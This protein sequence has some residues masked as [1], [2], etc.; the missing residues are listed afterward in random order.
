LSFQSF[1]GSLLDQNIDQRQS[2]CLVVG[3]RQ[4]LL[5]AIEI[6]FRVLPTHLTPPRTLIGLEPAASAAR[7]RK[8]P[9]VVYPAASRAQNYLE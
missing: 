3:F 8:R 7:E 5:I 9:L 6:K 2:L 1:L 4:Q